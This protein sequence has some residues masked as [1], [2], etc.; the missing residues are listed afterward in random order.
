ML[1]ACGSPAP[2]VSSKPG[3]SSLPADRVEVV[4]F[5]RAQRCNSCI[6]AEA[7]IHYTVETYFKDELASGKVI[8]KAVNIGD[9]ENATIVKKYGAFTSSL[10]INT[11]REGTD[12]IEEVTDIWFPIRQ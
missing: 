9:K 6:Y 11:I 10:F 8:F 4:Y 12:H 1:C 7:G 3:T 5:H 2:E